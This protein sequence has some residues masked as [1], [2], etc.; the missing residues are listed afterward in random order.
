MD[1]MGDLRRLNKRF[2]EQRNFWCI[3]KLIERS[4]KTLWE[5]Y[6]YRNERGTDVR[7]KPNKQKTCINK[8]A[9]NGI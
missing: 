7:V 2:G 9:F 5:L 4:R 3:Q 6:N 8:F 1:Y